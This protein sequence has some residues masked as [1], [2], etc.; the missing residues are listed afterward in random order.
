VS[1]TYSQTEAIRQ[2]RIRTE[3]GFFDALA[4]LQEHGWHVDAAVDY[5]RRHVRMAG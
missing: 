1:L 3:A 2:V 5:L 4:A